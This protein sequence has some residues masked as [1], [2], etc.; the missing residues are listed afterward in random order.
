MSER[1]KL[2]SVIAMGHMNLKVPKS[3]DLPEAPKT[4]NLA[5]DYALSLLQNVESV[6][7]RDRAMEIIRGCLEN[8]GI[9][10]DGNMKAN[11]QFLTKL[12]VVRFACFFFHRGQIYNRLSDGIKSSVSALCTVHDSSPTLS[13][14]LQRLSCTLFKENVAHTINAHAGPFIVDILERDRKIVWNLATR[15]QYYV[16]DLTGKM[17]AYHEL[18]AKILRHMGYTVIQVP[19]WQWDK[20]SNKKL[21]SEY[22]RTSRHHALSDIRETT[23]LQSRSDNQDPAE[24]NAVNAAK[25]IKESWLYHGENVHKKQIPKQQWCWHKPILPLRVSI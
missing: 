2:A 6:E 7:N 23:L 16:G 12:G 9:A 21:R 17:T 8:I 14:S 11:W 10:M 20:M 13:K 24:F 22:C 3:L 19:F 1:Q 5:V 18:K 25:Q 4:P 15:N